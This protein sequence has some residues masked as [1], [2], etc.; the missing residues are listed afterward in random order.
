VVV[1]SKKMAS[2]DD[3][4][5][6]LVVYNEHVEWNT[7]S[8]IP[9]SHAGTEVPF[10]ADEPL[11]S[12]CQAFPESVTSRKAPLT[13]GRSAVGVLRVLHAAQRS[14]MTSGQA[15]EVSMGAIA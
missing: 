5:K 13:D 7:G 6:K 14:L 12:E 15:V 11:R 1:G 4:L 3:V 8:P 9:V 2:L 10:S